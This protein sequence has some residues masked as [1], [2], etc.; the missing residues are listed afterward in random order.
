MA[1]NLTDVQSLSEPMLEY[2]SLGPWEQTSVKSLPKFIYISFKKMP[3]KRLS[4]NSSHSVLASMCWLR[5]NP[6]IYS[7]QDKMGFVSW[8]YQM[9]GQ[10]LH[11]KSTSF[12]L[13]TP[14][15]DLTSKQGTRIVVPGCDLLS[16]NYLID[17]T[18]LVMQT[19]LKLA[20]TKSVTFVNCS[21]IG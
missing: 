8:V 6:I 18:K 1:C 5:L 11:I 17:I 21:L 14:Y 10:L 4:Q 2:C 13:N 20:H 12:N 16:H 7:Y 9:K 19:H 3:L 15:D